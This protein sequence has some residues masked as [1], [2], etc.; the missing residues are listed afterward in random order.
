MTD[1]VVAVVGAT[2]QQGGAT[3]RALLDEGATVRGLVRDPEAAKA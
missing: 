1:K 3:V 2:G